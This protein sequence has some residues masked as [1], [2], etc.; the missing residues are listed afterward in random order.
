M[1]TALTIRNMASFGPPLASIRASADKPTVVKNIS[2]RLSRR[3]ISNDTR[4]CARPSTSARR[5][6]TSTPPTTGA[7]MLKRFKNADRA[8]SARP[9]NSTTIAARMVKS[10]SS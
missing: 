5:I 2:S 4:T 1:N 10:R 6:A 9:A 3:L 8:M 7:G